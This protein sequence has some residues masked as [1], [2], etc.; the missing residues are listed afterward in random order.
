MTRRVSLAV[1]RRDVGSTEPERRMLAAIN[2]VAERCGDEDMAAI[3]A[4]LW[5]AYVVIC[6]STG[7][8]EDLMR[9]AMANAQASRDDM[10]LKRQLDELAA[11]PG[12]N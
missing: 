2:A 10:A 12:G 5:G 7:H 6:H 3:A 9:I 8:G 4:T 11:K 1:L